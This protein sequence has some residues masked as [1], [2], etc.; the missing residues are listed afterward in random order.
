MPKVELEP[1]RSSRSLMTTAAPQKFETWETTVDTT[2]YLLRLDPRGR[3]YHEKFG[4]KAKA[5]VI[6][7]TED[8]ELNQIKTADAS[9]DVFTNGML[10]PI[11][12]TAEV[13][14]LKTSNQVTDAEILAMLTKSGPGFAKAVNAI[15]SEHALRRLKAKAVELDA[16]PTQMNVID[17]ALKPY[18][19]RPF[20]S[21]VGI[22][23]EDMPTVAAQQHARELKAL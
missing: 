6:L 4:G 21:V 14:E 17:E 22:S 16:R 5:R 20:S 1:E 11:R 3:E 18:A 2:M 23:D 12:A 10:I 19:P 8:R 15:S 13:A 7:T 9:W